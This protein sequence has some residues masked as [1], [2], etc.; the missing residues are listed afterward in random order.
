[1]L[2]I[3]RFH[4]SHQLSIYH[5]TPAILRVDSQAPILRIEGL[6]TPARREKHTNKQSRDLLRADAERAAAPAAPAQR[7]SSSRQAVCEAARFSTTK[8]ALPGVK[9]QLRCKSGHRFVAL[10]VLEFDSRPR[11]AVLSSSERP[12]NG[13]HGCSGRGEEG[14]ALHESQPVDLDPSL[15]ASW[16]RCS[17]ASFPANPGKLSAL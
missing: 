15:F 9:A 5:T 12:V 6:L 13:L 1:M 10:H 3:D 14:E 8:N 7:T 2:T 16:P 11:R 17:R 4:Q